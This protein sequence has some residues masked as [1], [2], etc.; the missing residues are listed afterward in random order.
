MAKTKVILV[1]E[2]WDDIKRYFVVYVL[3]FMVVL[4]AFSVIY[5]THLN[6]QA[7]SELEQL[8]AERDKLDVER[9]NLL[10]EQSSLAE[11]SVIESK[12]EKLLGMEKPTVHSEVI[13]N[14]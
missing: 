8:L 10:L 12:A 4:S 14:N 6:R 5:F 1:F 9:R 3:L 2:L 7:T 13:V 11:H